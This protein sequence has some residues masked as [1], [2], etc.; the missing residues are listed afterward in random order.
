[1]CVMCGIWAGR[2]HWSDK[3]TYA[4]ERRT[5]DLLLQEI[6]A[7][8]NMTLRP[9]SDD[10]FLVCGKRGP[11]ER[12]DT[13]AALWSCIERVSKMRCDPLEDGFL[14]HLEKEDGRV[15]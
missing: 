11:T 3:A 6:L 7:Y 8:Y 10:G 5:R 2:R 9:W 4:Q 12:T 15:A 1:M 14:K 13:L